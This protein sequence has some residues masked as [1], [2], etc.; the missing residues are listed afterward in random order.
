MNCRSLLPVVHFIAEA[1]VSDAAPGF[2][3]RACLRQ[4]WRKSDGRR[5]WGDSPATRDRQE[6]SVRVRE[7]LLLLYICTITP[8]RRSFQIPLSFQLYRRRCARESHQRGSLE[9]TACF[10]QEHASQLMRRP[11]RSA[12]P[13]V[14]QP[15]QQHPTT[16]HCHPV[17]RLAQSS[18]PN[19]GKTAIS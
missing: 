9:A 3:V 12:S 6:Q 7:G 17:Q 2:A 14:V 13:H 16:T 8:S 11:A 5:G 15:A 4:C 19:R 10:S 18:T 1:G